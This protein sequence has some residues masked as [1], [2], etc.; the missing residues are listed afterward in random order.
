MTNLETYKKMLYYQGVII[1]YNSTRI[2]I[3]SRA[4]EIGVHGSIVLRT[5]VSNCHLISI[6]LLALLTPKCKE[7]S[8]KKL[9]NNDA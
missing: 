6:P 7:L 1:T 8:N 4:L 2:Q 9:D 5:Q 3:F